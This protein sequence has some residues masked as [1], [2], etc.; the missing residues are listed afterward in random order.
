MRRKSL[1]SLNIWPGFVDAISTLLLV[2]VFLLAIFMMSQS[3]LTQAISGKDIAL[4]SLRSQ[5]I[6]LDQD[7]KENKKEKVKLAD[8]IINLNQ[9]LKN[10]NIDKGKIKSEFKLEQTKSKNLQIN[11]KELESKLVVLYEELGIE[12]L[13]FKK[14]EGQ[15]SNL[16]LSNSELNEN[17]K[18]LNYKLSKLDSLL[19]VK[20]KEINNKDIEVQTLSKKLD[21]ALTDKIGEL[22]EYRS[23]FFGKLKEVIGNEKEISIVGDR[24][25]LQS[26]IFFKSGSANLGNTGQKKI[27]EITNKLKT[28][29]SKIPQNIDWDIQVEGQTD[30]I[31]KATA[32]FPS[33]W[34]LSVARAIKVAKIMMQNGVQSNRI[35]VAGYGEF[36]PLVANNSKNNREKNRRIELKLTQP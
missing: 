3:F 35:N 12:K 8:L 30:N 25:V 5:L 36:R 11:I 27:V 15:N 28:I 22:A 17:I 29:F 13:N 23:E 16:R 33:N 26:E 6:R 32:N 1:N 31:P 10:I 7:L 4:A 14:L 19:T 34:E 2:F 21:L 18:V 20:N 24:F 9:E